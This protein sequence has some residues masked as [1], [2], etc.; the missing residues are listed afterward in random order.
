MTQS[1]NLR[2]LLSVIWI[3]WY[4]SK[5]KHFHKDNFCYQLL[6]A[7][8]VLSVGNAV[9]RFSSFIL[10]RNKVTLLSQKTVK[11]FFVNINIVV[12]FSLT[13]ECWTLILVPSQKLLQS[14]RVRFRKT[15]GSARWPPR[16]LPFSMMAPTR[17]RHESI[18]IRALSLFPGEACKKHFLF[19]Y[20]K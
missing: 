1:L 10:N 7:A 12:S 17:A 2:R 4:D 11:A 13:R 20:A 15:V 19:F 16:L 3:L 8:Y 14:P 6:I 9:L 18:A 5:R